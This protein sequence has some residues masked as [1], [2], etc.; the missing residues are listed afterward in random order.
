MPRQTARP[1]SSR[2]PRRR[3]TRPLPTLAALLLGLLMPGIDGARAADIAERQRIAL[4]LLEAAIDMAAIDRIARRPVQELLAAGDPDPGDAG[5]LVLS[6]LY[7][8]EMRAAAGQALALRARRLAERYP[9]DEL[10]ALAAFGDTGAGRRALAE[11]PTLTGQLA[12]EIEAAMRA[13][14]PRALARHGPD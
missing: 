2:A 8:D 4:G 6:A 14:M 1:A 5:L 13:V 3:R 11:D 10:Q 7:L 12:P 9:H